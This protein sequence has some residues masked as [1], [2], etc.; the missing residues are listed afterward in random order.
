MYKYIIN[1]SLDKL[2]SILIYYDQNVD[3][4]IK[5]TDIYV[6]KPGENRFIGKVSDF[7]VLNI[8][9]GKIK[10]ANTFEVVRIVPADNKIT[11]YIYE[12][13]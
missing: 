4:E 7:S 3:L 8:E 2:I 1:E 6:T 10:F 12:Y 13:K 11:V 5:S 9:S